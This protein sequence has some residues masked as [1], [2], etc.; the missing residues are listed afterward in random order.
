MVEV[1]SDSGVNLSSKLYLDPALHSDALQIL[2]TIC[3]QVFYSALVHA[4]DSAPD[5]QRLRVLNAT[6][7]SNVDM[8]RLMQLR[9][10]SLF[11]A[12]GDPALKLKHGTD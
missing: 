2:S 4:H 11:V 10:D 5:R 9:K 1:A 3:P 7:L 8:A 6:V 12:I